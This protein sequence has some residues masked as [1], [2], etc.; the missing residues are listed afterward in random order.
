MPLL[1]YE[2]VRPWAAAIREQ[3]LAG[4]M[5][6]WHADAPRGTFAN[7]RRLSDTEKD[8]IR[9]WVV[10][11]APKGDARDLPPSPKF[12]DNWQ[13]G[14]PDAVITMP[15]PYTVPATGEVEYQNFTAPT[16]FT[17]DKWVQAIEVR[18]GARSVVHHIL[19]FISGERPEDAYT[20]VV[21]PQGP[22]RHSKMSG[23]LLAT[24]APGTNALTFEPGTAMLVPAGSSLR[25]QI[26]YTTN[27]KPT[28][29][30]SSVGIIFAKQRPVKVMHTSAFYNPTFVLPAGAR[31]T[32]VPSAIEF[33]ENV[34][35][36]ALF[37]HTHLRGKS[38]DYKLV[39]PDGRTEKV[40][41]VPHYDFN[42]QTYYVF[43][44]PLGVPKG[45][46]LEA[47]AHY[48]NSVN[49]KSNPDPTKDV[50]WG[51]QTWDEMQYTGINYTV[52]DPAVNS[53]GNQK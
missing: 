10:L 1:S 32:E 53:T 43:A 37:P 34:H 35:L 27:G 26:H 50:R 38:W 18:P 41:S 14:T 3:V 24:T 17:E 39:Y 6:P 46:K 11:G 31:D 44:T 9:R 36:T 49:N 16:N 5:P 22:R 7:D 30:Q 29:D 19:V 45:T 47:V 8:V 52:D 23:T 15:A 13:I 4:T 21:P 42:W 25:F 33:H 40:L 28:T 48:D 51:E 20:R 2:Q 12:A